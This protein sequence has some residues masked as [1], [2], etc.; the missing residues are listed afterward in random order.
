[1][2]HLEPNRQNV[3]QQIRQAEQISKRVSSSVQLIAVSKTFSSEHIRTLYQ[4]GQRDFG[5]NYIQEWQTKTE[6]LSDCTD[7]VWH[8]IGHVQS[9]KSRIVAERAHWLH[10]LDRMKLAERLN[11]QRPEHLPPLNV[12]IEINIAAETNKHG[13]APNELLPL[14][15][16]LTQ[17]PRLNLR[18][19]MCVASAHVDD[20]VLHKQFG[21]M[22]HLLQQLQTI[23]P[24]A[25]ILSMGMSNDLNT[26]IAYGANMVRIGS[27]IFGKR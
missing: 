5:E 25:D 24:Q 15:Q 6:Q 14:A 2:N 26:A 21:Q 22:Q 20:A 1:M 18:G 10:T 7:L 11:H 12:L 9:N 16:S 19:L 8:M 13:I 23:T 4:H 27:S 17:F 3:L